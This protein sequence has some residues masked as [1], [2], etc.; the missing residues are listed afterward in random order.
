[1][2]YVKEFDTPDS[3]FEEKKAELEDLEK[4]YVEA[5]A[6]VEREE[7]N[8]K[9]KALAA[10]PTPPS[11]TRTASAS[12]TASSAGHRAFPSTASS[13]SLLDRHEVLPPPHFGR[14]SSWSSDNE[15]RA[16]AAILASRQ[17][18]QGTMSLLNGS[19]FPSLPRGLISGAASGTA[20]LAARE[21]EL[22]AAALSRTGLNNRPLAVPSL[23]G[24][25]N[26]ALPSLQPLNTSALDSLRLQ[27]LRGSLG[28]T[29][30]GAPASSLGPPAATSG[31]Y[32]SL[33]GS[34]QLLLENS[35]RQR[36]RDLLEQ[37]ALLRMAA[38]APG[39]TYASE[40]AKRGRE[41]EKGDEPPAKRGSFGSR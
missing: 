10:A 17:R 24:G 39:A 40:S 20:T 6:A 34:S 15:S 28:N 29:A 5:A 31:L 22:R 27:M 21:A 32:D 18:S 26:A 11:F 7:E 8:R 3:T 33:A 36:Q 37:D 38:S 30:A 13:S 4:K 14:G 12:S 35:L 1:M 9:K 19:S 2:L 25:L 41:E 16:I 23:Y